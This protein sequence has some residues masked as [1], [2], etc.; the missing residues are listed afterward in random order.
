MTLRPYSATLQAQFRDTLGTPGAP[1]VIDDSQPVQAVAVVATVNTA[2]SAGYTQITDGTD[3]L[4]INTDGSIN[5]SSIPTGATR[6]RKQMYC[7]FGASEGQDIYT[8]TGGKTLYISQMT[9]GSVSVALFNV[10]DALTG[11]PTADTLIDNVIACIQ[12]AT[13]NPT[14]GLT[15]VPPVAVTTKVNAWSSAAGTLMVS[16]V[17]WEI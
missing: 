2:S 12:G 8:V 13:A 9:I 5:L 4:A 11:A 3:T 15:F 1:E 6:I 17:G 7:S 14:T 16:F 10:G